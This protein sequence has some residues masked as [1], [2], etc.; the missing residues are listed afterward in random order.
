MPP[1]Q[2]PVTQILFVICHGCKLPPL[3]PDGRFEHDGT[4]MT[5][6]ETFKVTGKTILVMETSRHGFV[7]ASPKTVGYPNG[8]EI[9]TA[10]DPQKLFNA[11]KD[12][13]TFQQVINRFS[14]T[15][16][17]SDRT[18]RDPSQYYLLSPHTEGVARATTNRAKGIEMHESLLF[19]PGDDYY[20]NSDISSQGIFMMDG[21]GIIEI[22]H[23]FGLVD[24]TSLPTASLENVDSKT[25]RRIGD[26]SSSK[27]IGK[28]F[29]SKGHILL[30][31]ILNNR[32]I[33]D[34]TAV[35]IMA[36]KS[37][38]GAPADQ[39]GHHGIHDPADLSRT[40]SGDTTRHKQSFMNSFDQSEMRRQRYDSSDDDDVAVVEVGSKRKGGS[41]RKTTMKKTKF[42]HR[43]RPYINK[44]NKKRSSKKRPQTKKRKALY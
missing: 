44:K 7:T 3:P 12:A 13:A 31:E 27:Y 11:M 14:D 34:G 39:H 37:I 21:T 16:V 40:R 26:S 38:C 8:S 32:V 41:K 4:T 24:I 15:I 17:P 23:A 6:S 33:V 36:C 2:T 19:L 29:S 5:L 30:S 25:F 35:I 9:E 20:H 28:Y 10:P 18:R 43:K 22:P 1:W 42:K